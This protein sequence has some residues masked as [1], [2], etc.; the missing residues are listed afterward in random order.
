MIPLL[1]FVFKPQICLIELCISANTPDAP[2]NNIIPPNVAAKALLSD[3]LVVKI[4]SN[5]SDSKNT[6]N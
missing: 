1:G 6:G 4:S 2:T 5:S 3:K